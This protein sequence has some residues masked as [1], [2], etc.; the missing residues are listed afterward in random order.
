MY[1]LAKKMSAA[2]PFVL[3]V[4]IGIGL[5][6]LLLFMVAVTGVDYPCQFAFQQCAGNPLY[7]VG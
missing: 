6:S 3:C 5:A 4:A 7:F 2:W 1:P